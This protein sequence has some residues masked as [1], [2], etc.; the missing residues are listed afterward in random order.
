MTLWRRAV[1]VDGEVVLKGRA[2]IL[3][4]YLRSSHTFAYRQDADCAHGKGKAKA[5]RYHLTR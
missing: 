2:I 1:G 4:L 3:L 5:Y